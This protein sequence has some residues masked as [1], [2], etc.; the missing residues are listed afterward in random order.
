[1]GFIVALMPFWKAVVNPSSTLI[2]WLYFDWPVQYCYICSALPGP[3]PIAACLSF[4][5]ITLR[6]LPL[7]ARKPRPYFLAK[8]LSVLRLIRLMPFTPPHILTE[9]RP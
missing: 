5:S 1:M 4:Q 8:P 7:A 2:G 6:P 9:P 3:R